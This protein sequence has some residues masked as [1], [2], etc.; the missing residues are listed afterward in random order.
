MIFPL[1]KYIP[2]NFLDAS[3]IPQKSILGLPS[4][5]KMADIV[6]IECKYIHNKTWGHYFDTTIFG[7]AVQI[8]IEN[9]WPKISRC[10]NY[11]FIM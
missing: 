9:P 8:N 10:R 11:G 2:N 7:L 6:G 1:F 3:L 5:P 4:F